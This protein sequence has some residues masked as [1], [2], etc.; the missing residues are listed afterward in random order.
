MSINGITVNSVPEH[1][2]NNLG[3]E[4]AKKNT[5]IQ[6]TE[7]SKGVALQEPMEKQSFRPNPSD[8]LPGE[9]VQTAVNVTN[10]LTKMLGSRFEYE[11]NEEIDKEIVKIYE[12][13]SGELIKQIPPDDLVNMLTKMYDM[14]GLLVDKKL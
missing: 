2:Q 4:V 6:G 5:E 13:D 8:D 10:E 1:G 3:N 14:M 9:Q 7:P 11:Y 12:R